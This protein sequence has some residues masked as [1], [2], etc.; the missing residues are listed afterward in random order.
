MRRFWLRSQRGYIMV[1]ALLVSLLAL[2]LGVSAAATANAAARMTRQGGDSTQAYY[3]AQAG[4]EDV[5]NR[6]NTGYAFPTGTSTY[7]PFALGAGTYSVSVTFDGSANYTLAATGTVRGTSR[8]I[9]ATGTRSGAYIPYLYAFDPSANDTWPVVNI[10]G[11]KINGTAYPA[12]IFYQGTLHINQ[13]TLGSSQVDALLYAKTELFLSKQ[14]FSNAGTCSVSGHPWVQGAMTLYG[15]GTGCWDGSTGLTYQPPNYASLKAQA[16]ASGTYTQTCPIQGTNPLVL[17]H[18]T[19]PYSNYIYFIDCSTY[20]A[21]KKGANVEVSTDGLGLSGTFTLVVYGGT[22][23]NSGLK[24]LVIDRFIASGGSALGIISNIPDPTIPDNATVSAFMVFDATSGSVH[25]GDGAV[26]NGS[27]VA[28]RIDVG[29]PWTVTI[30]PPLAGSPPGFGL[31]S[32][33][34][35]TR[36]TN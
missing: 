6:V 11:A 22:P 33:L 23:P 17:P 7:G 18:N 29:N 2:S 27:V 32:A 35:F 28:N 15:T 14:P 5:A 30:S 9:R 26:L 12:R 25:F 13:N 21:G 34:K 10:Q 8:T 36:W 24:A 16:Q 31:P 20:S 19:S 3:L 1:M 4:I